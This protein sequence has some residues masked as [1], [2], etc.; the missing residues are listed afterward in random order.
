MDEVVRTYRFG[1]TIS[2]E[3]G[4][5]AYDDPEWAADAAASALIDGYGID[6]SYSD[7]ESLDEGQPNSSCSL[8]VEQGSGSYR[9]TI[10]FEI[11]PEHVAFDDPEWAADAAHGALANEYGIETVYG[12][13]RL[14]V[15]S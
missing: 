3:P 15:D 2:V 4:H 14:I 12:N 9:F 6:A 13:P 7:I 1:M 8:D 10:T 5:A 11:G